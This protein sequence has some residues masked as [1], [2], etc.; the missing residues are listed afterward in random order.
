MKDSRDFIEK[1]AQFFDNID[2]QDLEWEDAAIKFERPEMVHVSVRIPKEDLIAIKK[3]A[4]QLGVGYSTYIRMLLR[5][6]VSK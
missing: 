6:E 5:K 3:K 1:T 2:T 4:K